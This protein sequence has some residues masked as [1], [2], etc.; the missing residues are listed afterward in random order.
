M[1]VIDQDEYGAPQDV[2]HLAERA[3]PVAGADAHRGT[4]GWWMIWSSS[5][6]RAPV[7]VPGSGK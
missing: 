3:M 5:L 6:R 2:L 1:K 4:A 7:R